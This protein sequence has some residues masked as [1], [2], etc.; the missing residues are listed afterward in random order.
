M[1]SFQILEEKAKLHAKRAVL[2][3]K[4][5]NYE[6]AIKHYK[7]AIEL[8]STI[9]K[10]YPESTFAPLYASL[11]REYSK[12]IKV[13]EQYMESVYVSKQDGE[14]DIPAFEIM[15]PQSRPKITFKDVIGLDHVKKVLKKSILYPIRK[16]ELFPLGWPRGILLFGPPGCGKTY[17]VLALANEANAVLIQV[18][19]ANIMSKWL[20]EAEKNVARLFKVAR[21]T[22][23]KNK[24]VIIFIDEV[25]GLL[26]TYND[27]IGGEARV[28]NQF[29]MEMDGLKSKENRLLLFVIGATNKPWLLDIGFIRRFEK[30]IYVPPP[31]KETRKKLFEYFINKIKGRLKIDP[32]VDLDKLAEITKGYSSFDIETIT[33]EVVNNVVSEH[34]EKTGGTGEGEPR[35]ITMEDFIKVIKEIKPS[36]NE[37]MIL[38]YE[39]WNEEFKS[40]TI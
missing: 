6:E 9:I 21:E 37:K 8:F 27:E 1:S 31:D 17:L 7:K 28:R 36:I 23:Q 20:G 38:A 40:M 11:I 19:A 25:D 3:D 12:R 22:A 10:L 33:R 14:K 34:F 13:L 5:G 4:N 35:P 2:A 16:P 18:S 26:R 32:S 39:K 24:P 30:R 29:L 15:T